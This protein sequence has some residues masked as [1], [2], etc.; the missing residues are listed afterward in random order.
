MPLCNSCLTPCNC[1]VTEDGFRAGRGTEDGRRNTVVTGVGT[2]ENPFVIQFQM[3]GEYRPPSGEVRITDEATL[4]GIGDL[5]DSG[6]SIYWD[7]PNSIFTFRPNNGLTALLTGT[8]HMVGASASFAPAPGGVRRLT[9]FGVDEGGNSYYMAGDTQNGNATK[10]TICTT[11]GFS[12]GILTPSALVATVFSNTKINAWAVGLF[13]S[14]G[15]AINVQV[16]F[17]VVTV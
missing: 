2:T 11:S 4:S 15:V 1:L 9:I 14:A 17:W 16:K 13:Q 8:Y 3:S 10:S 5:V 7:S 6:I 12:A